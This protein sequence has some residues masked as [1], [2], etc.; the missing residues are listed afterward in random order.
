MIDCL[1]V[2]HRVKREGLQRRPTREFNLFP[3]I[4]IGLT[5]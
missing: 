5:S 1:V 3:L 4:F 2:H